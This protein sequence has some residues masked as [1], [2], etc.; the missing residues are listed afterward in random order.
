MLSSRK[1]VLLQS[2]NFLAFIL[3]IVV[4]GL[5]NAAGLNGRTT[6]E[7]SDL[8]PY[9]SDACRVRFLDLGRNLR[10]IAGFCGFSSV[11]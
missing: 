2:L 5:A 11:A 6:A 1:A 3:T 4:N 7:V 10:V 9:G 8:Y